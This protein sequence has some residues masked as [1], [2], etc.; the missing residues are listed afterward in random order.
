MGRNN[1]YNTGRWVKNCYSVGIELCM[2][3]IVGINVIEDFLICI[4]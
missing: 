4:I 3:L 2:I 1:H